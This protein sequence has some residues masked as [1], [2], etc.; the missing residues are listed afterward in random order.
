MD[1]HEYGGRVKA[2]RKAPQTNKNP[3]TSWDLGDP[4]F[5][6]VAI[7]RWSG[8]KMELWKNMDYFLYLHHPEYSVRI[9]IKITY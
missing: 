9:R 6:Q 8:H 5:M 2:A 4:K 1:P 7:P 3:E